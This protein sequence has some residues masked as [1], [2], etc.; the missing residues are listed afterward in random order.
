MISTVLITC[1]E[2]HRSSPEAWV[3]AETQGGLE[4]VF[5][6]PEATELWG[7]LLWQTLLSYIPG[8]LSGSQNT[9]APDALTGS[10]LQVI[11]PLQKLTT[12]HFP[13]WTWGRPRGREVAH[14]G[15]FHCHANK[16]GLLSLTQ[17]S[18]HTGT[19]T[20]SVDNRNKTDTI[21]PKT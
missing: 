5:S 18:Q 8:P 21:S 2:I 14:S 10:Q 15:Q 7:L 6:A 20:L 11:R 13:A 3:T 4:R 1:S 17:H 12:H 16:K 9:E 19:E